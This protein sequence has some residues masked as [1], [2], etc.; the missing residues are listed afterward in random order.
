M[1]KHI[2]TVKD[3]VRIT[4]VTARTLHYY[5]KIDLLKPIRLSNNGYRAYSREDLESLRTILFF[6]EMDI[7]L[8]EIS[9]IMQLSKQEQLQI[10]K[11]H[12]QT[13]IEKQQR[14]GAIISDLE[15]YVSGKDIFNLNIFNN[16]PILPLSEQYSREAKMVFGETE[17]YK[18]YEKNIEKLSDK[19]KENLYD[20][21]ANNM[22]KVFKK[23]AEQIH[24]LPSSKDIQKLIVE[25]KNYMEQNMTCDTEILKCIANTYKSDKR[26]K[27][28]INQFSDEDLSGF[29]YRAIMYYCKTIR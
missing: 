9:D 17:K 29:V 15:D 2:F 23:L 11:I 24:K 27:N 20:E 25:W 12:D 1:K 28:Y 6:K 21:F 14:L 22:E 19:E 5:D 10:L 13:L 16:S 18:E 7:S 8:K 26:W 4:G 3:I